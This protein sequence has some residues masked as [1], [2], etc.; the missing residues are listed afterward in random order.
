MS[1]NTWRSAAELGIW[2]HTHL[3]EDRADQE[4]C[5]T[6]YGLRVVE[7]FHKFDVLGPKNSG[8][9]GLHLER[10]DQLS[11]GY[12][13]HTDHTAGVRCLRSLPRQ[14]RPG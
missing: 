9:I 6:R 5:L 2:L 4:D 11:L 10:A 13:G 7:R 12:Q 8:V 14:R 3:A 1:A